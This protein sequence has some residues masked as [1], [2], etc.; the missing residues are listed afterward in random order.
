MCGKRL[1]VA[2][3]NSFVDVALKPTHV[4]QIC[5]MF[6]SLRSQQMSSIKSK[7]SMIACGLDHS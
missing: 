2:W 1:C 4:T 7:P 5:R 3:S 6:P